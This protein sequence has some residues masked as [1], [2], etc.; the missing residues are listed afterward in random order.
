M[1]WVTLLH[2]RFGDFRELAVLHSNKIFIKLKVILYCIYFFGTPQ[3][4]ISNGVEDS[5]QT[6]HADRREFQ[7]K[8]VSKLGKKQQ[9][10]VLKKPDTQCMLD[11]TPY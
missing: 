6:L 10:P 2:G 7:H 3:T 4:R 1:I 11:I 5:I 8:H 9:H